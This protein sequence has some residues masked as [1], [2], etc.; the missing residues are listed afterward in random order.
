MKLFFN[1]S[2]VKND[3]NISDK[4]HLEM[5]N[6]SVDLLMDFAY[7][8]YF[9]LYLH[10]ERYFSTPISLAKSPN[11]SALVPMKSEIVNLRNSLVLNLLDGKGVI[12]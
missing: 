2:T 5:H 11:F 1:D 12:D 8:S 9:G 6:Y 7:Y 3:K 4:S 10:N